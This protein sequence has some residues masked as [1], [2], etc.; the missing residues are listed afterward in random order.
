[1]NIVHMAPPIER[2]EDGELT[3][4]SLTVAEQTENQH[5]SVLRVI[6]ENVGD[7]EEFGTVGFEIRPLAG[8][9]LPQQI[10]HLNEQQATLLVTYLRNNEKVRAFKKALVKA[11][12]EMARQLQAPV[13]P[14]SIEERTLEVLGELS[15]T[16]DAQRL[17]LEAA[18]P[19][20]A[21]AKTYETH[22]KS[23][24]RQMFAR[25]VCAWA[26]DQKGTAMKQSTVTDF[27]ARK[28]HLFV[29]GKRSD[30]GHA[31]ADAVRR[32]LAETAKGT[33]DN[34]HNYATGKL[35]AAG[36]S[37]AWKRITEYFE[38]H[39]TLVLPKAVDHAA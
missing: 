38:E 4:S 25:E 12:H 2:A 6:R 7:F 14:K 24:G 31:T 20:I 15:A 30:N 33:A 32:G 1:M 9:G 22:A 16:V 5:A 29:A 36:Q 19:L 27:L 10:A 13:R 8:G 35:T 37:Y 39:G 11:F 21:R 3:V 28:L 23:I 26:N 18:K 17:E 34:G